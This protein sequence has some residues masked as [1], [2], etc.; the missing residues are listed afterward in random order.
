MGLDGVEGTLVIVGGEAGAVIDDAEIALQQVGI[1]ARGGPGR[2]AF[3]R[4]PLGEPAADEVV[5][6]H[7]HERRPGA[8]R[9]ID[10]HRRHPHRHVEGT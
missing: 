8:E 2:L 3:L 5:A 4:Q 1:A 7:V 10:H 6:A 9:G